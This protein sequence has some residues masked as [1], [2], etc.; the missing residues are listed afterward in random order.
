MHGS[1]ECIGFPISELEHK[2]SPVQLQ[3]ITNLTICQSNCLGQH[4]VMKICF[5][6]DADC[7]F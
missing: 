1:P 7:N 3:Q 2:L 6:K 5:F 4:S